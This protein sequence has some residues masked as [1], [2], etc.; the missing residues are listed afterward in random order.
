MSDSL[1]TLLSPDGRLRVLVAEATDA[2]DEVVRR[3]R[4]ST[5]AAARLAADGT[6][7]SLLMSAHVKDRERIL[8]EVQGEGPPFVFSGE[9]S[10]DGAV[11]ARLR[12]LALPPLE[13]LVGTISAVKWNE[14]RELYRGTASVDHRDLEEVLR[15]YLRDSQQTLGAVRL[16]SRI[17]G[18]RVGFA[19]GVLIERMPVGE[20]LE[21]EAFRSLTDLAL[22]GDLEPVVEAAGSGTLPGLSLAP[23]EEREVVFRCHCSLARVES[24]ICTLGAEDLRALVAE[25]GEAEV[26][27]DFC[28]ERYVVPSVRLLELADA[29]SG[30]GTEA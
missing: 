21:S 30:V 23:V 8:I 16:G 6:V 28:M 12:P 27:C 25:Q 29:L 26:S 22:G 18:T 11:R 1:R 19:G 13:R 10:A 3:H 4:L 9:A 24:S 15:A 5:S 17:D 20:P 14:D 7:L 2:A